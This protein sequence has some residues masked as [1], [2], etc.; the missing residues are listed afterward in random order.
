LVQN[1]REL[2]RRD[3]TL[4]DQRERFWSRVPDSPA[5]VG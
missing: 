3:F 2:A 4:S 1:A 5:L